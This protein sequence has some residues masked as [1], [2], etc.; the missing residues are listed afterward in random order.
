MLTLLGAEL[1]RARVDDLRTAAEQA[2]GTSRQGENARDSDH[3]P[4]IARTAHRHQARRISS[5]NGS[6]TRRLR[7]VA[8]YW[9]GERASNQ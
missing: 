2:N 1:A 3:V 4:T 8:G 7:R 5:V 9:R 6:P